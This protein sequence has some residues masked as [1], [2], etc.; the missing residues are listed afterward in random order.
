M[1][2]V[3]PFRNGPFP[4]T[5]GCFKDFDFEWVS[6]EVKKGRGAGKLETAGPPGSGDAFAANADGEPGAVDWFAIQIEGQSFVYQIW[7]LLQARPDYS[8]TQLMLKFLK[9]SPLCL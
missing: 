6:F 8:G 3:L 4:A 7:P 9:P 5:P 2:A 1:A